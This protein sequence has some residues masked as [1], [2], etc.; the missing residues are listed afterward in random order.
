MPEKKKQKRLPACVRRATHAGMFVFFIIA[1]LLVLAY[2]LR[3]AVHHEACLEV[4]L[5]FV[6]F[7]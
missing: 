4:T 5:K 3:A 6:I 7:C 2:G 1:Y